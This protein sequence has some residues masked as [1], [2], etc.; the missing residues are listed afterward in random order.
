M[1]VSPEVLLRSLKVLDL[2]LHSH[3]CALSSQLVSGDVGNMEFGRYWVL[4]QH[5]PLV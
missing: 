4:S 2:A 1:V 5:R 3:R